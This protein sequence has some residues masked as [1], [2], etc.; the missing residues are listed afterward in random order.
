LQSLLCAATG[1]APLDLVVL[2]EAPP[3][4]KARVV[5]TGLRLYCRDA[6]ADH[7]FRRD[8]QLRAADLEPFLR[9]T[10]VIKRQTLAR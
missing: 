6:E 5:T 9:R 1:D 8:A 4:L 3:G 10:S 7:A 2:N